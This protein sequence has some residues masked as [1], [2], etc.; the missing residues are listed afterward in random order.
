MTRKRALRQNTGANMSLENVVTGDTLICAGRRAQLRVVTV[1]RVTKTQIVIGNQKYRKS[2]GYAFG[3]GGWS[4]LGLVRR[5]QSDSEITE[6]QIEERRKMV[7][8]QV[9][10]M[11]EHCK[12]RNFTL[13]SLERL[14]AVVKEITTFEKQARE[15]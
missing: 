7:A 9:A 14:N 5:P 1:D 13:E 12:L 3:Q 11:C 2:N 4:G 8:R 15:E 6:I 10:E